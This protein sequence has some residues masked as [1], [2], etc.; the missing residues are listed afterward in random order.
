MYFG[1]ELVKFVQ[2]KILGKSKSFKVDEV[3]DVSVSIS[4]QQQ[5]KKGTKINRKQPLIEEED[6]KVEVKEIHKRTV[7]NAHEKT[8][9]DK[10]H[11][12]S[13][14]TSKRNIKTGL[15]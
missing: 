5:P 9:K 2:S 10:T 15:D 4:E 12:Q 8:K 14:K 3:D 13:K 11:N 6:D 1:F 7:K